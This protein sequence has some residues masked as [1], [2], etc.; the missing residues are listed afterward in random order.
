MAAFLVSPAASFVNGVSLLV[1]GG[2]YR[3]SM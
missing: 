2:A 3:G 1:D